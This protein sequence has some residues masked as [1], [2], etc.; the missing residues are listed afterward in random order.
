MASSLYPWLVASYG[1]YAERE[2]SPFLT[3]VLGWSCVWS[4]C[5]GYIVPVNWMLITLMMFSTVVVVV[6]IIA[7]ILNCSVCIGLPC[8]YCWICTWHVMVGLCWHLTVWSSQRAI[9]LVTHVTWSNLNHVGRW[10]FQ[11]FAFKLVRLILLNKYRLQYVC[12]FSG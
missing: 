11:I 12:L 3:F 7:A 10:I 2:A 9:V 1:C 5:R 6:A 8:W 4:S